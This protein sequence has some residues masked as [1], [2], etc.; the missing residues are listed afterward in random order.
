[1]SPVKETTGRTLKINIYVLF[2]AVSM[3]TPQMLISGGLPI[4][5]Y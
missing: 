4:S 3:E 2:I 1:M 5:V